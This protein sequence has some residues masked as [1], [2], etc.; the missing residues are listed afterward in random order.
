MGKE[1]KVWLE[2]AGVCVY[3]VLV[4]IRMK[5]KGRGVLEGFR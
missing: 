3:M 5:Q 4:V 2:A 1:S